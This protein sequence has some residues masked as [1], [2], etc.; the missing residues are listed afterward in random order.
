MRK[1]FVSLLSLLLAVSLVSTNITQVSASYSE[2]VTI[3]ENTDYPDSD[4]SYQVTF[5]YKATSED[6]ETVSLVG[7]FTFYTEDQIEAVQAGDYTAALSPYEYKDGMF[8]TGY[9]V[10]ER[11]YVPLEMENVGDGYF[12]ITVPLPGNLYCYGFIENGDMNTIYKDSTNL[13]V[14]NDGSDSGWSLITIGSSDDCLEGQEY[15]YARTDGKTGTVEYVEYT[16]SDGS[17]QPLGVYLPYGYD[18]SKTYKTLYLSHGGGGNEVE[19]MEIGAAANIMDNLIAEG[20]IAETIVVTMDNTYFGWDMEATNENII[21]N[22]IPYIE[23]NYS[24]STSTEDRAFAGLSNGGYTTVNEMIAAQDYFGYYGVFSPNYRSVDVLEA[25][26][27]EELAALANASAYYVVSGTVDDGMGAQDRY[28]T[29]N[30]VYNTLVENGANVSLEWKNGAHDWGVWRASLTTFA[31]DYLWEVEDTSDYTEGVTVS[32]N[33]DYPDTDASYQATFVYKA[34]SDVVS[35]DLI[36]NFTFYYEDQEQDYVD[37]NTIYPYTPYEYK[38]GMLNTGYDVSA[39]GYYPLEMENVGNNTYVI[40]VPLPGNQYFYGF[41]LTYADDDKESETVVDP[42]N[43]PVANGDSDSGWSLF[44]CG[45]SED[46]IE[47]QEYIYPRTDDQTGTVQYVEYTAIDETTQPLGI[48]LPYGYDSSKTYKTLYLSHG[49]GGNEVEWFNIG[50]A[51]NIMDNLIASGEVEDTIVVTMDNT[52][53]DF[54]KGD[55]LNNLI[56]CI[57]PYIEANYSVSTNA[58]DRALAGLSSGATVTV[59]A[60]LYSNETFGY[61]GVFSPSRTLD[62]VEESLTD[63]MIANFSNAKQYYVSVGIFDSF[64]RRDVNVQVYEELLAAGAN[65]VFEWKNGA[66]DWG[67][68]RDQLSEFVKDYLWENNTD[69]D[70]DNT[71]AT[72]TPDTTGT[73]TTGT[74]GTDTGTSGTGATGTSTSTVKTGDDTNV[75]ILAACLV[76]AGAGYVVTRRKR[77]EEE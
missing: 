56:E 58:E 10:S 50:S 57:I 68:W 8:N 38:D 16:A 74:T 41:Q 2:G 43:I 1:M 65:V 13:P 53:F 64:T 42:T 34:A 62:F 49:G 67:V 73:D 47:G 63:E 24:V 54:E 48:Y 46:C 31:K 9:G 33:T 3:S 69:T 12:Q 44:Y 29:V 39:Y 37:G 52:Y 70:N 71:D 36:G 45:N 17:T 66:H 4:A 22:I 6:V 60:M 18:S 30:T 26:S 19:W 7:N 32:E 5:T 11:N 27:E 61:Y 23:A 20:E 59:Q 72:V 51:D 14:S 55:S 28:G 21:N 75:A 76:A 35:V 77:K 15:I 40:T 25:A